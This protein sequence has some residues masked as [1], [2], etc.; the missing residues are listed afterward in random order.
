MRDVES[1]CEQAGLGQGL[2]VDRRADL[3]RVAGSPRRLPAPRPLRD[4][5]RG[6]KV[7]VLVRLGLHENRR[8]DA[9]VGEAGDARITRRRARARTRSDAPPTDQVHPGSNAGTPS[10]SAT[11][12]TTG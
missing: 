3:L 6:S 10:A 8:A 9:V 2:K 1:L 7:G 5:L 12:S 4:P 11:A